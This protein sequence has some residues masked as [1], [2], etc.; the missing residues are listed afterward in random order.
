MDID[1]RPDEI[2]I[3]Q[4]AI[5]YRPEHGDRFNGTL[6]VTTERLLYEATY[7]TNRN[8]AAIAEVCRAWGNDGLLRIERHRII[9][10]QVDPKVLSKRCTV[11]VDDGSAHVFDYGALNVDAVADAIRR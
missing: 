2:E 3:G 4:W 5:G 9:D 10:V 1:L 8:V 11:I 6:L 7:D